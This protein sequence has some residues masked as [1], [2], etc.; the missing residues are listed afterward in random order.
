MCFPQ[1]SPRRE[2][3]WNLGQEASNVI[4]NGLLM[5][6]Y[7]GPHLYGNQPPEGDA[8]GPQVLGSSGVSALDAASA[9][10]PQPPR[11]HLESSVGPFHLHDLGESSWAPQ[12]ISLLLRHHR[13]TNI[14]LRLFSTYL[15]VSTRHSAGTSSTETYNADQGH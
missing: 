3:I 13:H 5:R 8:G 15:T 7:F 1:R 10:S 9:T 14:P 12:R 2:Y 11:R 6:V 4:A